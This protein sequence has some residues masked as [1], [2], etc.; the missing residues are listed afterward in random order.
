MAQLLATY[1]LHGRP[2]RIELVDHDG[3]R[4]VI[5]R[6]G[7]G[8]AQVIA[9]LGAGEGTQQAYCLLGGDGAYLERA[10][11]GE[12]GLCRALADDPV[13]QQ[14]LGQAA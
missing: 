7:E 10:R 11:S 8:P 14:A 12:R 3:G 2:H 1:D 5:D 4:L 13:E 9:E 6:G